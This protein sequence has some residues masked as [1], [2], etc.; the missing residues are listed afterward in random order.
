MMAIC[1]AGDSQLTRL[2]TENNLS[3]LAFKSDYNPC[4]QP[5]LGLGY[6]VLGLLM[7]LCRAGLVEVSEQELAGVMVNLEGLG[8]RLGLDEAN[9]T[10][11]AKQLAQ[12]LFDKIPVLVG[13]EFLVGNL[14]ILRNQFN[15]ISK[16]LAAYLELPDMNHY[17]LEGLANP[18]SN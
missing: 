5:R 16:N 10:N 6:S 18:R 3:G 14:Q 4:G 9:P 17:A 11:P 1:Q 2:M 7:L 15:E 12:K 8:K 13:A